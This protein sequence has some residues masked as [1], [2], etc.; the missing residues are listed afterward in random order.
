MPNWISKMRLRWQGWVCAVL[1]AWLLIS[2]QVMSYSLERAATANA[3]GVGAGVLVFN[4]IIAARFNYRGEDMFN[5]LLGLWLALSP[6]S[7]DFL[8]DVPVTAN[9]IIVG[10]A[11][12]ALATSQIVSS[13]R[14]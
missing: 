9:A 13:A 5:I 2:P 6:V 12:M 1:G 3:R 4:L 10:L 8:D 11:L 14:D 7:L